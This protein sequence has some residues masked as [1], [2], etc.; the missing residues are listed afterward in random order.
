MRG[1]LLVFQPHAVPQVTEFSRPP[2]PE[3][4]QAVVGGDLQLVPGFRLFPNKRE[5]VAACSKNTT[6]MDQ[7]F[8]KATPALAKSVWQNQKR[9]SARSV[10][11]AMTAAGY[12]VHFTTVARWKRHGWADTDCVHPLDQARAALDSIAPLL[13]GDPMTKAE[14]LIREAKD[15]ISE[16]KDN[17]DALSD[18][19][20]LRRA[21]RELSITF[22]LVATA[23]EQSVPLLV[24]SR[25]SELAALIDA[26]V[27]C[28]QAANAATLQAERMEREPGVAV[29]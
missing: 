11:R 5:G 15:N 22:I 28:G 2:S 9:P 17:L 29:K 8:P 16:V 18:A 14:D 23:I 27:A 24:A 26:L 4:V 6:T 3:E 10:A 21:A 1:T 13:T 20:R 25:P 19:E 7:S 12:P